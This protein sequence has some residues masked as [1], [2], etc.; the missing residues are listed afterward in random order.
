MQRYFV[1]VFVFLFCICLCRGTQTHSSWVPVNIF[2]K[3]IAKKPLNLKLFNK[4]DMYCSVLLSF[5]QFLTLSYFC[6]YICLLQCP[7]PAFLKSSICDNCFNEYDVSWQN[8]IKRQR[9]E[10]LTYLLDALFVCLFYA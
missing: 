10:N 3:T 2:M 8:I 4:K 5:F 7:H 9:W 6:T 1:F